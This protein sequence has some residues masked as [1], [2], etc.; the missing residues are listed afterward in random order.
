MTLTADASA[1]S[2]WYTLARACD[3]GDGAKHIGIGANGLPCLAPARPRVDKHANAGAVT[4]YQQF[5]TLI[6]G[7]S[8][9]VARL[10]LE[11]DIDP[12]ESWRPACACPR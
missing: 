8:H 6:T 11:R 2:Y 4:P 7:A 3:E 12:E 1:L 5:L 9:G 10:M